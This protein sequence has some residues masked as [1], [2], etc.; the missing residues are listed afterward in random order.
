MDAVVG[1]AVIESVP[2]VSKDH[3][4]SEARGLRAMSVAAVETRAV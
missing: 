3:V 2:V 1:Y 4:R